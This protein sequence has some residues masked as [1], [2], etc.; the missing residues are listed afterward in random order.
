MAQLLSAYRLHDN[1]ERL[2]LHINR[3]I[4]VVIPAAIKVYSRTV[5]KDSSINWRPFFT[6]TWAILRKFDTV[7][8][9]VSH[10]A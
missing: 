6:Y 5:G 8:I 10:M 1:V 9:D 3:V 4:I 7:A 2:T